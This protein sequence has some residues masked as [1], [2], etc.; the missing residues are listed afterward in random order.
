MLGHARI[1]EIAATSVT[2]AVETLGSQQPSN[3]T[4]RLKTD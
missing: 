3:V 2:F 1:T 4:L